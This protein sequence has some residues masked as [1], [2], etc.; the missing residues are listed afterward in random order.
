MWPRCPPTE[1]ELVERGQG[2]S[3]Q[4]PTREAYACT[5]TSHHRP[6]PSAAAAAGFNPLGLFIHA[7]S[8]VWLLPAHCRALAE[9]SAAVLAIVCFA[10]L[11]N[12]RGG[13]GSGPAFR[14]PPRLSSSAGSLAVAGRSMTAAGAGV[15]VA[16]RD[17]VGR[18]EGRLVVPGV[19]VVVQGQ[20]HRAVVVTGARLQVGRVGVERV[21]RFASGADDE[22]A[23]A[24]LWVCV[25]G[26]S[27]WGEAGVEVVVPV[28]HQ[29]GA[30]PVEQLPPRVRR[31]TL[32]VT[33]GSRA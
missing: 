6:Q 24:P 13:A 29:V 9:P 5:R 27:H 17:V 15:A 14:P 31:R 18:I 4:I 8:C 19:A 10:G 16:A 30:V 26:R 3:A 22:L 1:E 21:E 25:A 7:W 28:E 2:P 12:D 11:D 32:G 20:L 23:D 33:A